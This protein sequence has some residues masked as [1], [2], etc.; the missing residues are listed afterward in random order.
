ARGHPRVPR[1]DVRDP[2]HLVECTRDPSAVY[3][4][5]RTLVRGAERTPRFDARAAVVPGDDLP[6]ETRRERARLS[7]D[8]RA[9][10]VVAVAAR[11]VARARVAAA[12][13]AE[14]KLFDL[15][16]DRVQG[17]GLELLHR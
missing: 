1:H 6:V 5:W 11:A 15:Q 12:S 16:R 8:G 2:E 4:A 3:E 7:D 13:E 17:L 9:R 14:R 10:Q